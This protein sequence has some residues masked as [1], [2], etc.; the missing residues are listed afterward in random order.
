MIT[1]PAWDAV[2]QRL[3]DAETAGWEP[4]R[5]LG[6][7]A[8]MRETASADSTAEV[9][10]WRI[11]TILRTAPRRPAETI[12]YQARTALPAWLPAP[13]SAG[14]GDSTALASYLTEAATLISAR[15]G[16]SQDDPSA[17]ACYRV[18]YQRGEAH[19]RSCRPGHLPASRTASACLLIPLSCMP[20]MMPSPSAGQFPR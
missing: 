17:L 15:P 8:V 14:T 1:N 10:T 6:L 3:F 20:S 13:P 18:A 19:K 11:D 2:A 12:V 9:L 4:D 7:A 5:L 16:H